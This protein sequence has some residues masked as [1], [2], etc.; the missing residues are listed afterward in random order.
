MVIQSFKYEQCLMFV[1]FKKKKKSFQVYLTR[2]GKKPLTLK[3][4]YLFFLNTKTT[5]KYYKTTHT[6]LCKSIE[7]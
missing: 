6:Y 7:K 2:C 1:G 4:K 3:T 5:I